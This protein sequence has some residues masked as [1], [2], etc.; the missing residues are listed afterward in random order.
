MGIKSVA[1]MAVAMSVLCVSAGQAQT[2]L[3]V[4][5]HGAEF[6]WTVLLSDD[7]HTPATKHTIVCD[8]ITVEIEMPT[9]SYPVDKV[10]A[11]SG[12]YTCSLFASN[13]FGRQLEPNVPFPAFETG[14]R[15]G[16]PGGAK[17]QVR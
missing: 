2:V 3:K 8:D 9:T 12:S 6:A 14:L 17:I 11:E 13:D 16:A 1:V 7:Q 4:P 5:L 10:V 15:P